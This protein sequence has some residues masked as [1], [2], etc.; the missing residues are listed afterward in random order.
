MFNENTMD[1][2]QTV[3]S[4]GTG[5]DLHLLLLG[6]RDLKLVNDNNTVEITP[7]SNSFPVWNQSLVQGFHAQHANVCR[8][9]KSIH[10]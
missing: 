6:W 2:K 1:L 5:F 7:T 8:V 9:H 3:H 10:Q 4:K